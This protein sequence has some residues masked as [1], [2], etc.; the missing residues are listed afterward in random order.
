[1]IYVLLVGVIFAVDMFFK[2]IAEK[3]FSL[4]H[5]K[6]IFFHTMIL[7]RYHNYGMVFGRGKRYHRFI[8][9]L[10][11]CLTI[12]ISIVFV[13]TLGKRGNRILKTGL[14]LLLG[15]AFCNTYDRIK[16]GYVVDYFRIN[17]PIKAI[18][19]LIFNLSDYSILIGTLM[20]AIKTG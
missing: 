17:I 20:I 13:M 9:M 7:T 19:N 16:R 1:M 18:R 5:E 10:A 6:K 4:Q 8:Q 14:S 15:G 2:S 3:I 12:L 11:I